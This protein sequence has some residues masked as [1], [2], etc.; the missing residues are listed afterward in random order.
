MALTPSL[1]RLRFDQ[2]NSGLINGSD[3][4]SDPVAHRINY[5]GS[6][7]SARGSA[8]LQLSSAPLG[9]AWL[10]SRLMTWQKTR[11][12]HWR[13]WVDALPESDGE[14]GHVRRPILTP[15][16]PVAS[17]RPPLHSGMAS[18]A[19]PLAP[20]SSMVAAKLISS[21]TKVAANFFS[22]STMVATKVK[23][24]VVN[25]IGLPRYRGARQV[26]VDMAPRSIPISNKVL[27]KQRGDVESSY[28]GEARLRRVR[29]EGEDELRP[30]RST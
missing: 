24:L 10:G 4:I 5:T 3:S 2:N 13:A 30:G 8:R 29:A 16:S 14:C 7:T 9:S 12:A 17:Y 21:S 15:F 20:L 28:L 22:S 18:M 27:S 11:G 25:L 6:Y 26:H 1:R 23:D 19:A